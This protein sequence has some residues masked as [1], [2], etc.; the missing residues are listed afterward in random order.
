[1]ERF[2]SGLDGFVGSGNV[3]AVMYGLIGNTPG[4]IANELLPGNID[5]HNAESTTSEEM[6]PAVCATCRPQQLPSTWMHSFSLGTLN[7]LVEYHL[8]EPLLHCLFHLPIVG[9]KGTE[10]ARTLA[11]YVPPAVGLVGRRFAETNERHLQLRGRIDDG[12]ARRQVASSTGAQLRNS[13]RTFH[14]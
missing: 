2:Q 14:K 9:D 12:G 11:R 6:S 5:A 8:R 3:K 10:A 4:G 7:T 1:M 13:Q